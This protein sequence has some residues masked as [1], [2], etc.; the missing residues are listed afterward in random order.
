[1]IVIDRLKTNR[2]S[3]VNNINVNSLKKSLD[4]VGYFPEA[5]IIPPIFDIHV[6]RNGETSDSKKTPVTLFVPKSDQQWRDF[7]IIAPENYTHT[8]DLLVQNY[9]KV[10][11]LLTSTQCIYSYSNP[12]TFDASA[13]RAAKQISGWHNLQENLLSISSQHKLPT[14]LQVDIQSCYHT[15]YTHS[16]EWAYKSINE[17]AFGVALDTSARRGNDNRTHGLPVGPYITDIIAESVLT[18]LDGEIESHLQDV[19]CIGLRF[20]DNYYILCKNEHEAEIVL[21]CIANELRSYHFTVNDSKTAVCPFSEYYS[22]RW[23]A[24]YDLLLESLNIDTENPRLTFKKLKVFLEQIVILSNRF[25]NEKSI[26]DKA[27]DLTIKIEITGTINY[28]WL[29]YTVVNMLPL[30]S[31]SYPKLLTFLKK[32]AYENP[33]LLSDYETFMFHEIDNASEREDLFTMLWIGYVVHDAENIELKEVIISELMH[34][35]S[36]NRIAQDMLNFLF[37]RNEVS[38]MWNTNDSRLRI[39]RATYMSPDSLCDYLGVSFGES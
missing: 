18:W 21:S 14:L 17:Q 7:K 19:D 8:V 9:D 30:R 16:I 35:E 11:K 33:A 12:I 2:D 27:I 10:K 3:R 22:S 29:F 6:L 28:R 23:Q 4:R 34:Y 31:M 13:G 15:L 1:M 39:Q 20:K 25:N 26:L 38:I 37:K 36:K 24:E 5:N 32:I